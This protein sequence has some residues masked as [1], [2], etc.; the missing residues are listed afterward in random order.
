[1]ELEPHI[2]YEAFSGLCA[3]KLKLREEGMLCIYQGDVLVDNLAF[4]RNGAKLW[5]ES[6]FS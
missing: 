5:V 6:T 4:V 1:M 3:R 2:T